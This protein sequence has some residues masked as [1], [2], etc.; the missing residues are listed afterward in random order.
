[1][2]KKTIKKDEG[3]IYIEGKKHISVYG[4]DYYV[5][6]VWKDVKVATG[7]ELNLFPTEANY[8]I[9]HAL[10]DDI[11]RLKTAGYSQIGKIELFEKSF[12]E[13]ECCDVRPCHIESIYANDKS[14]ME[15]MNA[16]VGNMYLR[17]KNKVSLDDVFIDKV[18]VNN[19]IRDYE[20]EISGPGIIDT[21]I[22]RQGYIDL[23]DITVYNLIIY[24]KG[25]CFVDRCKLGK[26][27][28]NG[29]THIID[30]KNIDSLYIP[31]GYVYINQNYGDEHDD[32]ATPQCN[33][34]ELYIKNGSISCC[35]TWFFHFHCLGKSCIKDTM[36]WNDDNKLSVM[37]IGKRQIGMQTKSNT[38]ERVD[39]II[40][41]ELSFVQRDIEIMD[42]EFEMTF[43][44]FYDKIKEI[45]KKK[46]KVA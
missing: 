14:G 8:I 45:I 15:L 38:K 30:T 37:Y 27:I 28:N 16:H 39:Y 4:T 25:E 9:D 13:N 18:V 11:S 20:A 34:S 31:K 3:R 2:K 12:Y 17:G 6:S 32:N 26:V 21:L 24:E 40:C 43:D 44:E 22:I 46:E 23:H 42:D 33:I 10:V 7:G 36:E 41:R 5:D 19:P 29:E 35:H 1:M